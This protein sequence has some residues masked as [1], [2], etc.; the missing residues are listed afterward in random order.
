MP[1]TRGATVGESW[2]AVRRAS[3]RALSFVAID[4]AEAIAAAAPA[5]KAEIAAGQFGARPLPEESVT[6]LEVATY[7]VADRGVSDDYVHS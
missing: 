5:Y 2:A 4:E 3:R 1:T 7:L 6:A